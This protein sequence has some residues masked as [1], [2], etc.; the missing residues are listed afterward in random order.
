MLQVIVTSMVAQETKWYY[1]L[2]KSSAGDEIVI[3]QDAV[4]FLNQERPEKDI[5]TFCKY[6]E[7]NGNIL[8]IVNEI[9]DDY[10][11][12]I[13]DPQYRT[14]SHT[15]EFMVDDNPDG[16]IT[17]KPIEGAVMDKYQKIRE[18]GTE[19][20]EKVQAIQNQRMK[21]S[22]ENNTKIA[23]L[24][25]DNSWLLGVWATK[26]NSS[27]CAVLDNGFVLYGSFLE[28]IRTSPMHNDDD[29]IYIP[30]KSPSEN[31]IIINLS[32]KVI[33]TYFGDILIKIAP[34]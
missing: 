7:Q 10:G 22:V 11:I 3:Y 9:D 32:A 31:G 28:Y 14:I 12:L 19:A 24:I 25:A 21:V 15:F 5:S 16:S 33:E 29:K 4:V 27:A 26:D 8:S 34:K 17:F 6:S 2:F 30:C 18:L 23:K 20:K 1:G 13:L